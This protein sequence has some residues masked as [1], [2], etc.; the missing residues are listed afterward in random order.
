MKIIDLAIRGVPILTPVPTAFVVAGT[1]IEILEK[2]GWMFWIALVPALAVA[3]AI[4]G[5]G[6][7]TMDIAMRM[8]DYNESRRKRYDLKSKQ[9]TYRDP[10]APV[11]LAYAVAGIYIIV[12]LMFT[13]L[14]DIVPDLQKYV[15][16][17]LPFLSG[18]GAFLYA[19]RTDHERRVDTLQK[20]KEE[21]RQERSKRKEEKKA[22]KVSE[23]KQKV[24][25]DKVQ[26]PVT[27]GQF[28]NWHQVPLDI[29][30]EIARRV[31]SEPRVQVCQ[32]VQREYGTSEKVAYNWMKYA[33]RDHPVEAGKQSSVD[34]SQ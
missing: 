8:R 29:Q 6:F 30:K 16:G 9:V 23:N 15:F 7:G 28:K 31:G 25:E 24:S 21:E 18:L 1:V 12:A 32:W 22:L 33:E 19:L 34:S 17:V 4:E 27:Y 3:L 10:R 20:G 14:T 11:S 26:K 13:V 2:R 5:L